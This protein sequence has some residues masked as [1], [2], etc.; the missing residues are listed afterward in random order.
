[1]SKILDKMTIL[2]AEDSEDI[3][4]II[5]YALEL[6]GYRILEAATGYEALE[7]AKRDLPHLILMDLRLPDLNGFACARLMRQ[8]DGL[9]HTPIVI[10]S[11]YD[12]EQH[13]NIALA[14]GCN[15]YLRKPL[16]FDQL[17]SV[18]TRFQHDI[19]IRNT[20]AMS[21]S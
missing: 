15:E 13:R 8:W 21:G 9:K 18:V 4:F 16:D 3:R 17:Y 7:I 14:A 6:K 12:P 20:A 5:R 10:I 1:M 11:S 2:V 19:R